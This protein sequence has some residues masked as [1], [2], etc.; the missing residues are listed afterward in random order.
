MSIKTILLRGDETLQKISKPVTRFDRKLHNL[1]DDML[2]TLEQADGVGL[3]APQVGILRRVVIVL[4]ENWQPI[5]LINPEIIETSGEQY[6][7]EG[8]L[9]IP[10]YYGLVSRPQYVKVRAFDRFGNLFETEGEGLTARAFCHEIDHL[11]GRLYT[12]LSDKLM[13]PEELEE[14]QSSQENGG[15]EKEV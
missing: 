13:T 9:S 6:G 8:C 15:N 3:A 1:L 12:E 11:N 7:P 4:N 10:G 5:E 2:E 14:Y